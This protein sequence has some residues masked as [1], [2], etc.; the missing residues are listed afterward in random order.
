MSDTGDQFETDCRAS[1]VDESVALAVREAVARVIKGEPAALSF[2]T[3]THDIL[4]MAGRARIDGWDDMAFIFAFEEVTRAQ[5]CGDLQLPRIAPGKLF[6]WKS[7]GAETFG[8]WCQKVVPVLKAAIA[9][10]QELKNG[11]TT[12]CFSPD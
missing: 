6:F 5:L 8:E 12:Q 1:G 2:Q 10:K 3:P 7:A 11:L 9:K 4:K